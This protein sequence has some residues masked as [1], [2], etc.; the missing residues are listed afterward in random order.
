MSGRASSL[1]YLDQLERRRRY[2]EA[3]ERVALSVRRHWWRR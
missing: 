1:A 2:L 3:L